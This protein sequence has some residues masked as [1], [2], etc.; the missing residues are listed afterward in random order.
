MTSTAGYCYDNRAVSLEIAHFG[1]VP[2]STGVSKMEKLS[3]GDA[4]TR[5]LKLNA[6]TNALAA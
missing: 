6:D 3:A 5:K 1:V 4:L 2:V